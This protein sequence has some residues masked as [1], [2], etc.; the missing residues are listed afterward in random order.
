MSTD[1][2][3]GSGSAPRQQQTCKYIPYFFSL[4]RTLDPYPQLEKRQHLLWANCFAA[5]R[6]ELYEQ[7]RREY[8]DEVGPI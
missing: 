7:I 6:V 1:P 5:R 4:F 8:E 2:I 3:A